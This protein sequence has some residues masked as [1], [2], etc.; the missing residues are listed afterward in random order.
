MTFSSWLRSWKSALTRSSLGNSPRRCAKRSRRWLEL[1]VLESRTLLTAGMLDPSFGGAGVLT[2]STTFS[3]YVAT[4]VAALPD[5]GFIVAGESAVG[6]HFA[7]ARY[8]GDGSP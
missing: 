5:G 8:N 2:D 7:V 1:E 3:P 4:Q 6:A